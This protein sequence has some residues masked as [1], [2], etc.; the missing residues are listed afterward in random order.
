[1]MTT[2]ALGKHCSKQLSDFGRENGLE[3]S[4]RGGGHNVA[5]RAVNVYGHATTGGVISTTGVAGLTLGGGL[6]W[7][8]GTNGLAV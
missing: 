7:L 6:G 8:M 3:I 2:L 1:M 5:G 4:V